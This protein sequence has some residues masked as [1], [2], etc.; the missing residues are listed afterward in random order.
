MSNV[1]DFRISNFIIGVQGQ[2][3]NWGKNRI[4]INEEQK[5]DYTK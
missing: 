1:E 5:E 4:K 2:E 3:S